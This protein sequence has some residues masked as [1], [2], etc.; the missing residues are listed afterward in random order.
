MP[1]KCRLELRE[2]TRDEYHDV[3]YRVM[4]QIFGVH[5]EF[6]RLFDEQ[7]YK[8]E[9]AFWCGRAGL[10]VQREV[11][12]DLTFESFSATRL[13]DFVVNRGICYEFKTVQALVN[14]HRQQALNYLLLSELKWGKLVNMRPPSVEAEYVTTTLT[15]AERHRIV[16]DAREWTDRS[17][18]G[19]WLRDTFRRLI[20]DWG[21]F[22]DVQLYYDVLCRLRGGTDSVLRRCPI[23]REGRELGTHRLHLLNETDAFFITAVRKAKSAR[24]QQLR[25]LLAYTDLQAIQWINLDRH[26]ISLKTLT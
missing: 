26:T 19:A 13:M 12:I 24:E 21:A 22:L 25:K 8:S 20:D 10:S 16:W 4:E 3:D 11:P 9:L 17:D 23:T 18:D 1:I 14:E 6:G 7:V 5:T 2:L 15:D